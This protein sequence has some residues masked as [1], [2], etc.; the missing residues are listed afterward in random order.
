MGFVGFAKAEVIIHTDK[1]EGAT[2]LTTVSIKR[3][4]TVSRY[5]YFFTSTKFLDALLHSLNHKMYSDLML[6]LLSNTTKKLLVDIGLS[7]PIVYV[8]V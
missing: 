6:L 2:L 7:L 3:N 1:D 4:T 8:P 5:T